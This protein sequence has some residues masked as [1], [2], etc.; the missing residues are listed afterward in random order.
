VSER[1]RCKILV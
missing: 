1:T